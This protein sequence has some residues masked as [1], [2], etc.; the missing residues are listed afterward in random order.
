MEDWKV[1]GRG[2]RVRAPRDAGGGGGDEGRG[3]G[4]RVAGRDGGGAGGQGGGGVEGGWPGG[5][6]W[7]GGQRQ[8]GG[9]ARGRPKV[10]DIRAKV[11]PRPNTVLLNC[12]AFQEMPTEEE[13]ADWFGDSLFVAEAGDLLGKVAGLDI[14]ERDKRI[15]V[16][17]SSPEDV[18]QL[19]I[20][21]G[22]EGVEW[23]KFLDPVTSQPIRIKGF[24]TDRR[25]LRVTLLDVPR[26]V[27]DDTIRVTMEQ[28]GKVE[29]VKRHHL[30]KQGMEHIL[31][32]RVS[33]K[34]V[35]EEEVEL[36]ATIF[37]LGSSTSSADRSIWRVMYAGAPKRCYRCGLANHFAR[38]CTRQPITMRQ[39]EKLPSVGEP[40]VEQ[41]QEQQQG[42][43]FP[44]SFAVVVK[45][46]MFI[47]EA[48]NQERKAEEERAAKQAKK[49]I[50]EKKREEERK[51]RETSKAEKAQQKKE[52]EEAKKTA[53]LA[54]LAKKVE[55]TALHKKY[56]K[57]LHEKAKAE[58]A[59]MTA[60]E[61]EME[62][63]ASLKKRKVTP[64]P[65]N[66]SS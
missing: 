57:N 24:S 37:G 45:S 22:D 36:P 38:E 63:M 66:G 44:R 62:D 30:S 32:N 61:I 13:V 14:E 33:I 5:Q 15:L 52:E 1:A 28:Y 19:L 40:E 11:Q 17:L 65:S 53:H 7:R 6:G 21:M 34:L 35:K 41:G 9:Q 4:A 59:E 43:I 51:A 64:Q 20:R 31:V 47:E 42:H 29:E 39:V 26:D 58:V 16:Q 3:G 46:P 49:Y 50:D 56:V 54:E 2:G 27:T 60:Y 25:I 12:R 55:E 8:A 10:P 18:E 48:A 23:L